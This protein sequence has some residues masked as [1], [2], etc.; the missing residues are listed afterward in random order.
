MQLA[1]QPPAAVEQPVSVY[2][3]LFI[4]MFTVWGISDCINRLAQW[5]PWTTLAN[6][7]SAAISAAPGALA[8]LATSVCLH[9]ATLLLCALTLLVCAL[10]AVLI[11]EVSALRHTMQLQRPPPRGPMPTGGSTRLADIVRIT[12]LECCRGAE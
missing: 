11:T 9:W 12:P 3:Q 6:L 10:L 8:A 5:V 4:S 2:T 7:P 1:H